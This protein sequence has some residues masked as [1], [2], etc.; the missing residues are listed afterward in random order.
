MDIYNEVKRVEKRM[1]NDEEAEEDV[2]IVNL[3][4]L[5]VSLNNIILYI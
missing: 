4:N 3:K 1:D 2:C 5:V